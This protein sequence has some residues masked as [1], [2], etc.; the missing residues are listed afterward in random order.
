MDRAE[1]PARGLGM[2]SVSPQD[3]CH[4][5]MGT[6]TLTCPILASTPCR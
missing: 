5:R 2:C 4:R 3:G 6:P 1:P